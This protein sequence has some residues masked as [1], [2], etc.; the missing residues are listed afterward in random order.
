[1]GR[2]PDG[3]KQRKHKNKWAQ[4]NEQHPLSVSASPDFVND[5][6]VKAAIA[7]WCVSAMFGLKK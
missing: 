7:K 6:G 5:H 4:K 3:Y 1:V 2:E